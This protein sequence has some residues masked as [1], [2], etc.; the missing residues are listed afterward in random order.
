VSEQPSIAV[1]PFANMSL[2]KEQEF[3]SDGL[4]EEIINALTQIPGLKVTARTSAFAFRGKDQDVRKIAEALDVRTIL[5]GSVRRSGDRVRVTAQLI[6]AADGYHLWSQRYDR[7]MADVFDMQEEI[8][9]AITEALQVKLASR[10]DASERYKP[11]LPAYEAY[12]RARHFHAGTP[13][14]ESWER[15][16]AL[17]ERAISLDPEFSSA[18]SGLALHLY[19]G[20]ILGWRSPT[21]VVPQV[22]ALLQHALLLDPSIPDGNA[23]LGLIAATFDYDWAEAE[24][25]FASAMVSEPV[26]PVARANYAL[27]LLALGR[28]VEGAKHMQRALTDDPLLAEY[29]LGVFL[30]LWAAGSDEEAVRQLRHILDVDERFQSALFYLGLYQA[31]R[32]DWQEALRNAEKAHELAPFPHTV[33]LLAGLL[34]RAGST[35]RVTELI[36]GLGSPGQFGVPRALVIF[37]LIRGEGETAVDWFERMIDQ[38]DAMTVFIPW[39]PSARALRASPRW[40]ALA[41][42]MKLPAEGR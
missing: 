35:S 34:A 18:Y 17:Y 9:T 20:P 11:S 13:T 38:R 8:A 22:R 3:F 31:A 5:E 28:P 41:T 10:S 36:S 4:A 40:L 24:R 33:G 7:Q 1:L 26:S 14:T 29:R 42:R 12:L 19:M 15:S 6:N 30:N 25:R 16:K 32:A 21:E 27:Y 23:M 37:H 2:D 39:M